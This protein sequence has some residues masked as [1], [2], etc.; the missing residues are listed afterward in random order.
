MTQPVVGLARA[1]LLVGGVGAGV[2]LGQAEAAE[3]LAGAELGQV[4]LLLLL[5]APA[6]DRGAHERGLHRDHRA[7]R[8]A[9]A[10]DLLDDQPVGQVVEA[11][12]AVLPGDDRAEVALLGHLGDQI[13]VEV[14]VAVVLASARDDLLVGEVARGLADRAS[15]RR[16]GRSRSRRAPVDAGKS[17][18]DGSDRTRRVPAFHNTD[19]QVGKEEAKNRLHTMNA[20][21]VATLAG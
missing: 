1:R 15:A 3:P 17:A 8:R 11:G 5:G 13:D 10:P 7:H 2:G 12:A 14:V 21:M 20:V 16:S 9:A 18:W 19:T 4:V 6:H